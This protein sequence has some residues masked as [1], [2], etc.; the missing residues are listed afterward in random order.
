MHI[1]P[2]KGADELLQW[3]KKLLGPGHLVIVDSI[4]VVLRQ[5]SIPNVAWRVSSALKKVAAENFVCVT[6][7]V[8]GDWN[9][10]LLHPALGHE[11]SYGVSCRWVLCRT[12]EER[13]LQVVKSG[14]HGEVQVPFK[15][16]R[17][18]VEVVTRSV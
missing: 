14:E 5:S 11:W 17:S 13:E 8:A 3:A 7:Q 9:T 6:N 15:I 16:T 1:I 4:T 12:G 18:G 2:L 10:G